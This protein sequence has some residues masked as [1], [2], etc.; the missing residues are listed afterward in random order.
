[1]GKGTSNKGRSD[2]SERQIAA[3]WAASG[4]KKGES[5]KQPLGFGGGGLIAILA[6]LV[7][8]VVWIRN[9]FGPDMAGAAVLAVF[10]VLV[11]LAG[12]LT[13]IASRQVD[14]NQRIGELQATS[15]IE[16]ERVRGE[17]TA[18]KYGSQMELKK[19]LFMLGML[20]QFM[21]PEPSTAQPAQPAEE[22]N[23]ID[24]NTIRSYQWTDD[25]L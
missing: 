14:G 9:D 25:D 15:A 22:A 11:Y 3:I 10:G 5:M 8:G 16:R 19:F 18:A 17:N 7:A 20:K 2:T 21:K 4:T 6:V 1:M 12:Q 23:T 13:N 24:L